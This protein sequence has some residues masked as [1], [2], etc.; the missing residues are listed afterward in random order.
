MDDFKKPDL[1]APRYRPTT[2]EIVNQTFYDDFRKEY[3]EYSALSGNEIKEKIKLI[4]S[5]IYKTIIIERDGVE[6]PNGLGVIFIGSCPRKKHTNIDYKKS[7]EYGKKISHRNWDSDE[8]LAKIFYTNYE[9]KYQFKFHDLWGFKGGREF[10][11]EVAK[12]YPLEW[13][14]YIVVDNL[15]RVALLFRKLSYKQKKIKENIES[16]PGYNDLALE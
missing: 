9:Q 3:P 1:H 7:I 11:R 5:T 16:L 4:N 10:K 2:L 6:L 13:A 8:Y 12:T 14:K 15:I